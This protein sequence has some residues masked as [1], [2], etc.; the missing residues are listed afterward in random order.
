[1]CPSTPAAPNFPS[2]QAFD[3]SKGIA[4]CCVVL[5]ALSD[6]AG[7]LSLMNNA[8]LRRKVWDVVSG[9]ACNTKLKHLAARRAVCYVV[10]CQPGGPFLYAL[11]QGRK[12]LIPYNQMWAPQG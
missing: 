7:F 9:V 2:L 3:L 10:I 5:S 8:G 4:T 11:P 1:V 12:I 6:P